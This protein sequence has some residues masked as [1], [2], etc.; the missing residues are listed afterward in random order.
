MGELPAGTQ[1]RVVERSELADGTRRARLGRE[2]G[3]GSSL[4]WVT[5]VGRDGEDNLLPA[6]VPAATSLGGLGYYKEYVP[7]S[8]QE[9]ARAN[10]AAAGTFD[11][12]GDYLRA[13]YAEP[14]G[15]AAA[16]GGAAK[17]SGAR[18]RAPKCGDP[19]LRD[20]RDRSCVCVG[21]L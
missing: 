5:C 3:D 18:V 11:V 1:V 9:S 17:R 15:R 14:S 10:A 7:E 20:S 21:V 16:R 8:V 6:E 2:G 19:W 12:P 4:G 13:E